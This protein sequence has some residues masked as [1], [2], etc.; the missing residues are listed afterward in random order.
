[1]K[2]ALCCY[3]CCPAPTAQHLP[4]PPPRAG[5]PKSG[6]ESSPGATLAGGEGDWDTAMPTWVMMDEV[7]EV[8]E[9]AKTSGEEGGGGHMLLS[10]C[11]HTH[12]EKSH[13]APVLA[14]GRFQLFYQS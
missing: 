13:P 6:L 3:G 2:S 14:A 8:D 4:P 11:F 1:M 12:T 9:G 5:V 10:V 7:E